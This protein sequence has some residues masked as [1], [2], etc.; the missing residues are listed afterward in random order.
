[1]LPF[2][3]GI[4]TKMDHAYG[5]LRIPLSWN[6]NRD[7]GQLVEICDVNLARPFISAVAAELMPPAVA[8]EDRDTNSDSCKRCLV[9]EVQRDRRFLEFRSAATISIDAACKAAS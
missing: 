4:P 8:P 7:W 5:C 1:M 9:V 6:G 2:V 3:G